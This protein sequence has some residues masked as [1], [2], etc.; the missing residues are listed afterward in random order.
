MEQLRAESSDNLADEEEKVSERC[1]YKNAGGA[2]KQEIVLMNDDTDSD[3][4]WA[5][6]S[7][8]TDQWK[9]E[10][11]AELRRRTERIA[12]LLAESDSTS[13]AF[14]THKGYLRELERGPLGNPDATEFKNAEI[15]IYKI[16]F[17]TKEQKIIKSERLI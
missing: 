12:E 17:S 6:W 13:V 2:S 14:V 7:T 3:T 5:N 4:K 9:E 1:R 15:R 11:K 10:D 8:P 16:T